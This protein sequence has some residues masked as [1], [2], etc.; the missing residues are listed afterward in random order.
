MVN[1][2]GG[3]GMMLFYHRLYFLI[4]ILTVLLCITDLHGCG[5][6]GAADT[7]LPMENSGALQRSYSISG[8]FT[9]SLTG[10]PVKGAQCI[11][12]AE[13]GGLASLFQSDIKHFVTIPTVTDENGLFAFSGVPAGIYSISFT[14]EKF[15]PVT[16]HHIVAASDISNLKNSTIARN[17]I[18]QIFGS[19]HPW[20]PQEGNAVVAIRDIPDD[21]LPG[22]TAALLP[23]SNVQI[24]YLKGINPPVAEWPEKSKPDNGQVSIAYMAP[25]G[26]RIVLYNLVPGKSYTFTL[27]APGYTSVPVIISTTGS[28]WLDTYTMQTSLSSTSAAS[29]QPTAPSPPPNLMKSPPPPAGTAVYLGGAF[30]GFDSPGGIVQLTRD[31]GNDPTFTMGAGADGTVFCIAVQKDGKILIGGHFISYNGNDCGNIVRLN[32]DGSPDSSFNTGQA[33]ADDTVTSLLVTDNDSIMISGDFTSYNGKACGRIARLNADGSPDIAFNSG[34]SGANDTVSC[35]GMQ[36]DGLILVGGKFSSYNDSPCNSI[37]RLESDGS[38][39]DSFNHKGSGPNNAV[40]TFA[41]QRDD[42]IVLGG[43]F[44]AYNETECHFIT[45]LESDG[46]PDSTFNIVT[47]EAYDMMN[48]GAYQSTGSGADNAVYSIALQSDG[49]ILFGGDF[50]SYDGTACN[51]IGRLKNDGTIDESFNG[52]G[53]GADARVCSIGIM[54]DDSIIMGGNF[55]KYNRTPCNCAARL[56]NDGT[57]DSS[58]ADRGGAGTNG[59]VKRVV[60]LGDDRILLGGSFNNFNGSRRLTKLAHDGTA[61]ISFNTGT[62]ADFDIL[63]VVTQSD[64][65]ILIGGR[66]TSFNGVPC[67]HL[68]RLNSDGTMDSTFNSGGM[69]ADDDVYDIAVQSNGMILIGGL[70]TAYNGM[71][72]GHIA[73]LN[74]DGSPDSTFNTGH[75]G[76]AGAG[77]FIDAIAL[78]DDG[79]MLIGGRFITYNGMACGSI[80]RLKS[81][82]TP[83]I[84]FNTGNEGFNND[85]HSLAVTDEG[86]ILAGGAFTSCNG[87]IC[88]YI[89]RLESDGMLDTSFNKGGA[90]ADNIVTAMVLSNDGMI[91]ISGT[92]TSYNGV[93]CGRITRLNRDGTLD[94]TFNSGNVGADS[95]IACIALQS[96]GGILIGGNFTSYNGLACGNVARL[97]GGGKF[98]NS[99]NTAGS[100]T[101]NTVYSIVAP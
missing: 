29:I 41:V 73:R 13:E 3:E 91:V 18:S 94:I 35:L 14:H 7:M 25:A 30:T 26:G 65:K 59:I 83:E 31:G 19:D 95:T 28:G 9:D 17:R 42:K 37:I 96:N 74:S 62:G 12:L 53:T 54:S 32:G 43:Q 82:G 78:T 64:G 61:D 20:N 75:L 97:D 68:A 38:P 36:R 92:F 46:T 23:S 2:T 80:A 55:T 90:G 87:S 47:N 21:A 56:E 4:C 50:T 48:P 11:L 88:S 99:F 57:V 58:F 15:V 98:D 69:G 8:T 39:D 89:A 44:T 72:C 6:N 1:T 51:R 24:G 84:S 100:G 10:E 49:K 101:D 52:R 76:A 27:S 85:V 66:F 5:G 60:I 45:R 86:K 34:G 71:A 70:F 33:G 63:R 67:S 79:G 93:S 40:E 81:D 77:S 22:L 16:A